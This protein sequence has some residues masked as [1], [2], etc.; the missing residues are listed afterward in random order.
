RRLARIRRL[1][2]LED[3]RQELRDRFGPIP[4]PTEWMLRL[5][6]LRLLAARWQ[7]ATIHLEGPDE[8][9]AGPTDLVLG[10]RSPRQIKRLANR[11]DGR[12]RIVDDFSAYYRLEG[13]EEPPA[14]L[15]VLLEKL[16]HRPLQRARAGEPAA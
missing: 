7:I 8:G 11:G 12:L 10:Y 15:Y 3:F 13:P 14:A 4:E 1:E 6:K 2:R 9:S 5:A 16:L